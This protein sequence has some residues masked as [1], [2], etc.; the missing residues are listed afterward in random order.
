MNNTIKVFVVG[1][2]HTARIYGQHINAHLDPIEDIT[3]DYPSY[4]QKH[5]KLL[6]GT[7]IEV[8]FWGYP[9]FKC[10]GMDL[11]ENIFQNTLSTETEDGYDLPG[12]T[13]NIEFRFG[14]SRI[15][16]ADLIMPW[17]GYVDCRNWLPKYKN[18][19]MVVSEYVQSFSMLFPDKKIRYIEPFPQFKDL[20]THGYFDQPYDTKLEYDKEF[21]GY[22]SEYSKE[23]NYLPP[24][25]QDIV[26]S[27]VKSEI[28]SAEFCREGNQDI[29]K[30]TTL[31]A[32]KFEYNKLVYQNLS[33]E[34]K[35]TVDQLFK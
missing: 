29:H 7:N 18:T 23:Y 9:G 16:E 12:I 34:I 6:I 24:I 21:R 27:A 2:C 31:D 22:L 20:N 17:L 33:E 1:D 30:G 15:K 3:S 26:Y 14:I 8:N 19:K 25:S 4:E 35:K 28:L 10:F 5:S 13:D 11:Q 32:L